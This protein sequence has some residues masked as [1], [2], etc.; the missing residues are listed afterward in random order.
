MLDEVERICDLE[1]AMAGTRDF[2]S[3]LKQREPALGRQSLL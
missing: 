1:I 3:I 2:F